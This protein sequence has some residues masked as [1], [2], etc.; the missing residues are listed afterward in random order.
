MNPFSQIPSI[1][2]PVLHVLGPVLVWFGATM[3][4]PLGL[5]WLKADGAAASFAWSAGITAASGLVLWMLFSRFKRELTARHG[6]LLVTLSWTSIAAFSALPIVLI[7]PQY[8]FTH[9]FF[10]AM[11]CLT[12]TGA[13]MMTGLDKLPISLNGWRC[14]L[15]WMGGMG[16]IVL[17]VAILPLLGVG[18]AQVMKAETSGPLKESRLTPRIAETARSLYAI[19]FGI[20]VACTL[21]YHFAGM[22]WDDAVMHMMTTV[23]LSGISSHDAS[24]AYFNNPWVDLSAIIFMVICGLN[25][26]LHFTAWHKKNPLL[27]FLDAEARAWV[28]TLVVL[29]AVCTLVLLKK[30]IYS[31]GLDALRAAAFSVASAASTTG[32]ATVDY[33]L[34]P[35]PIPFLIMMSA[36]FASCAGSTGGG[37]KMIRMIVLVKQ[38][39]RECLS[40]MTPM[41]VVPLIVGKT[42]ITAPILQGIYAYFWIWTMSVTIGSFALMTTGLPPLES[43]SGTIACITNLGPGL[44]TV[45]PVGNYAALT[46]AQLGI[47]SFLMLIGRLEIFT[48]LILFTKG[49]WRD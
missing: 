9:A 25:F 40:L 39:F 45:G 47:L 23:S 32:Y 12:T 42:V 48:V 19:Y 35:M 38:F 24:Y 11:S 15:S 27:Y 46:D 30:G 20:S 8:N 1:V 36:A 33:S 2:F 13:T 43:F 44:G 18:G 7:E 31:D 16:L 29:T 4:I 37:P 3:L 22:D 26:S 14:F 49:F 17:S 28:S 10:E 6:F 34:W 21:A 41:R 5:S